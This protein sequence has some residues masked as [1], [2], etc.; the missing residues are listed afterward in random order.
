[1]DGDVDDNDFDYDFYYMFC[2]IWSYTVLNI[3]NHVNFFF[4]ALGMLNLL[5][6]LLRD[7]EFWNTMKKYLQDFAAITEYI[8]NMLAKLQGMN[9]FSTTLIQWVLLIISVNFFRA[10]EP[11]TFCNTK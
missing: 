4:R 1:M 3:L 7:Q 2:V 10:R 8:N 6:P 9:A 11:Q 5:D